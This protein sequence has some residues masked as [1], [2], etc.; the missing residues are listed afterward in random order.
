MGSTASE[1]PG[2]YI[3]LQAALLRQAPRPGEIDQLTARGWTD[4]QKGLKK[5]LADCLLPP[6]TAISAESVESSLELIGTVLIPT[7]TESFVAKEK[8]VVNIGCDAQ[9]RIIFLGSNFIGW[10]LSGKGKIENP[11]GEHLLYY[12]RLRK[13]WVDDLAISF[14]IEL[15]GED[16]SETT[17]SEI[18]YLIRKQGKGNPGVLLRRGLA[19]VFYVRDVKGVL[20]TVRVF[21]H[22]GGWYVDAC[23]IMHQYWCHNG[24]HIFSRAPILK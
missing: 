22:C 12:T 11:I 16:K 18:F 8:F 7:I 15:G 21:W 1:V 2:W 9:V 14:I 10:F 23:L 19:N 17:L 24:H 20:R 5:V 13:T 3:E 6:P 4:N